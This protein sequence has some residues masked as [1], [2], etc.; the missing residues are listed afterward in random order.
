MRMGIFHNPKREYHRAMGLD[1]SWA[2]KKENTFPD[3]SDKNW[4]AF[5]RREQQRHYTGELNGYWYI[6]H[7]RWE[8]ERIWNMYKKS[9]VHPCWLYCEC[10]GDSCYRWKYKRFSWRKWRMCALFTSLHV[11]LHG[12]INVCGHT[13]NVQHKDLA[14][15]WSVYI[16][17]SRMKYIHVDDVISKGNRNM[18][19]K[20]NINRTCSWI[21]F[22]VYK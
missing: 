20:R 3:T 7:T 17:L 22:T 21:S 13:C 9:D 8:I 11:T 10:S 12:V 18:T 15:K 19:C 16:C 6:I 5:L 14:C 2:R 4:N 1:A